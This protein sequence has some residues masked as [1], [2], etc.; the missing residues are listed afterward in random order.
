[1]AQP[2]HYF[3]CAT[4]VL[5]TQFIPNLCH[6]K[7][8]GAHELETQL[9]THLLILLLPGQRKTPINSGTSP[10][11]LLFPPLLSFLS[12]HIYQVAV[13]TH[14]LSN[15]TAPLIGSVEIKGFIHAFFPS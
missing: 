4:V 2:S 12:P 9:K 3:I 14:S 8:I 7:R 10:A 13:S 15:K 6:K 11:L 5:Y 1:M